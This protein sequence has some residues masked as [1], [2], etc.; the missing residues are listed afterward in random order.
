MFT[1]LS[2]SF[3]GKGVDFVPTRIVYMSPCSAMVRPAVSTSD[4][5]I[6]EVAARGRVGEK[7]IRER[8]MTEAWA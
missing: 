7:T 8:G 6:P 3:S 1:Q 5:H 4:V 2:L